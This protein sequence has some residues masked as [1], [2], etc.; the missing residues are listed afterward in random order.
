MK[1]TIIKGKIIIEA[2]EALLVQETS[3]GS[4]IISK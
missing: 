2:D 3:D 1:I 4:L